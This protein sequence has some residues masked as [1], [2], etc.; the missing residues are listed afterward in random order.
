MTARPTTGDAHERS[1]GRSR[2]RRWR[3][4]LPGAI[5]LALAATGLALKVGLFEADAAA[6][7]TTAATIGGVEEAVLATGI[8]KP[9]KMV[10]VGAQVSGRITSLKVALGQELRKGDLVAE[11][12]SLTQQN[13]LRKAEATLANTKAQREEK[14]ATLVYAES[15]L[16]RQKRTLAQRAS[17]QEDH[18]SALSTVRVTR[19]QIAALDA[20]IQAAEVDIEN[21]RVNLG[22]TRIT[23]PIDGTVLSI[24]SQ[25]GATVNAAQ[26]APT[27]V[28]LGQ[29]DVMTVRAEISEADVVKVAPGQAVYFTILGDPDHRYH[30]TLDS[31]EPAPESVTSDSSLGS[32]ASSSSSSSSSSSEAIYYNG[33]FTARNPEGRLRTYM[34]TEVHIVLAAATSVV[35]IPASA[36]GRGATGDG[37]AD[38]SDTVQVMDRDGR[39]TAR[40]VVVGLN[41]KIVAEIRSGLEAGERVVTGQLAAT[42]APASSGPGG[43]PP[44]GF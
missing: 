21:A 34:T 10:A 6:V 5:L 39:I 28:I 18:D 31:I 41:D 22:Y 9:V 25:E 12:D 7:M 8:L 20:D 13:D 44:M 11:I 24:V 14:Q 35:T 33:V 23:A 17:S 42:T 26:S 29:L 36:L 30:A 16:A 15:V 37:G 32:S 27:I 40:K 43:G 4:V 1:A 19:A 2:T 38:G 3:L